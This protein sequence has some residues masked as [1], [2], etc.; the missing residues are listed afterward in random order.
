MEMIDVHVTQN[1]S[2]EKYI[3]FGISHFSTFDAGTE[4]CALI[5][6]AE[7]R[8]ISKL[9]TVVEALKS[10]LTLLPKPVPLTQINDV[11]KNSE[12]N[13]SCMTAR[14]SFDHGI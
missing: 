4:P 7:G 2:S 9:V 12:T 6:R 1:G 14:L 13:K 10:A 3:A 8:A 11:Y 5:F